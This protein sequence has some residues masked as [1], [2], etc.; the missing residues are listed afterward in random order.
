MPIALAILSS[1]EKVATVAD[2]STRALAPSLRTIWSLISDNSSDPLLNR[3]S[4]NLIKRSFS[5]ELL[6]VEL[7]ITDDSEI[8]F[9][10]TLLLSRS[11]VR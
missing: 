8:S 11:R 10:A 7:S 6:I 3:R 4:V 5:G 9:P 2:A 1:I